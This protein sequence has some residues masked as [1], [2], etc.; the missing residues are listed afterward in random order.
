MQLRIGLLSTLL[1]DCILYFMAKQIFCQAKSLRRSTGFYTLF[2]FQI[3]FVT[4]L[5]LLDIKKMMVML[6]NCL[7]NWLEAWKVG[8]NGY[9]MRKLKFSQGTFI[10]KI[11]YLL[12]DLFS[13]LKKTNKR[14]LAEDSQ[15]AGAKLKNFLAK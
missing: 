9:F 5:K 10:E 2:Y 3:Y 4:Y 13:I 7:K 1:S 14:Q 15:F 12:L 11:A 6:G 8:F